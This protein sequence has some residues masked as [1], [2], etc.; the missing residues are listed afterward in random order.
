MPKTDCF[1]YRDI[2][3]SILTECVCRDRNCRFYKT[4]QQLK[5]QAKQCNKRLAKIGYGHK[6]T[7]Y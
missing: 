5:E 4:S 3:C 6:K 7:V 1:A 2:D